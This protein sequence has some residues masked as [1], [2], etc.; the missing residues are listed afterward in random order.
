MAKLRSL[1]LVCLIAAVIVSCDNNP[2]PTLPPATPGGGFI[3][4]TF[5]SVN[6]GPDITEPSVELNSSWVND[7]SGAAG[8]PGTFTVI[9]SALGLA[10]AVGKRAPASWKFTWVASADETNGCDGQSTTENAFLNQIVGVVCEEFVVSESVGNAIG[11]FTMSPNP[12]YIAAPPSTATVTGNGLS[13]T[14]GMPL[15]QYY[16]LDGTLVA[17]ENATSVSANTMQIS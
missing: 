11:S 1:P 4:E 16:T 12:V 15:V 13:S 7:L 14:N 8:D 2:A 3:I 9:T 10:S 6:G 5:R 17:Q